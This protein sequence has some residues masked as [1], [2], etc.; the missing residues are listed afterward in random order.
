[1]V[2]AFQQPAHMP[3]KEK[4]IKNWGIKS[5]NESFGFKGTYPLY[6]LREENAETQ[7][8]P[9][10]STT[11][12]IDLTDKFTNGEL[13]WDAPAGEWTIIRYGW[14]CTGAVT[15]TNSDGWEGFQWIT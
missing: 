15:S 5:F 11:G 8:V 12:I 14:T 4:A 6:K 2:Q 3:V 10:I 9:G 1:M 7:T 13:V